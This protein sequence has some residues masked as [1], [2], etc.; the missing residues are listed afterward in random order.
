M[1]FIRLD[2]SSFFHNLNELVLKTGSKDKLA[3]V[4]KDNAYGHGLE[5]IAD[6]AAQYGITRAVVIRNEEAFGIM[7]RFEQILVLGDFPTAVCPKLSYAVSELEVLKRIDPQTRIEL[8]ID[9]GMHRNGIE[10]GELSPALEIIRNRKLNLFGVMTH[11]RSADVLSSELFWQRKNFEQIKRHVKKKGFKQVRYHSCNTAALLR[12]GKFDDDIARVGI[13]IYGYSG[14]PDVFRP[15]ELRPVLSL[16]ARRMS[17]RHVKSG[18]RIGYAGIYEAKRNMTVSTYDLGYGD[19]WPRGDASN[20]YTLADGKPLLGRVSMDFVSIESEEEEICIM[21]DAQRAAEHF[22]TIT[23]EMTTA[24]MPG[25]PRFYSQEGENGGRR[26]NDAASKPGIS[27]DGK[28]F[29]F[30]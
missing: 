23:Y 7:D 18:E 8:K 12:C 3:V 5:Q 19:G 22:G 20:P 1:A 24:L 25:I 6:M 11:Y 30:R 29:P 13:G 14:L 10:P 27:G 16:W 15:P 28:R 26:K 17:T 21:D 2:R 4:L 9:T